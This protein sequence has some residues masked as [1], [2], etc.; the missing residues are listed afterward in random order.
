ML[1]YHAS[2]E[3]ITFS[4]RQNRAILNANASKRIAVS[5]LSKWLGLKRRLSDQ[6]EC[7][8][9]SDDLVVYARMWKALG[10]CNGDPNSARDHVRRC[11]GQAGSIGFKT[12]S[13]LPDCPD[14]WPHVHCPFRAVLFV[15]TFHKKNIHF[16][17]G[18]FFRGLPS[19]KQKCYQYKSRD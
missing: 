5:C 12:Q 14:S 18:R 6:E 9:V 11:T 3:A 13:G 1:S 17:I 15:V 4:R 10:E 8:E 7:L 2:H 19:L 16:N